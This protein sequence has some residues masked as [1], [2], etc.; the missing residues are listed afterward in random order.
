MPEELHHN[1][2]VPGS[3]P[4]GRESVRSST[5]EHLDVSQN[6]CR[7]GSAKEKAMSEAN[8][9]VITGETGVPIKAWTK[10]VAVE[11]AARKQLLNVAAW[12]IAVP[13]ATFPDG[14]NLFGRR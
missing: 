7:H 13:G 3:I 9:N 12:V 1:L 5:V 11:D 14:I 10:G 8:Y 2:R 4:G 6:Y